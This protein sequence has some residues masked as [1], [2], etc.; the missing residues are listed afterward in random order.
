[1]PVTQHLVWNLTDADWELN[2]ADAFLG[3]STDV[4]G[5]CSWNAT[6]VDGF[7]IWQQGIPSNLTSR[8]V[9]TMSAASSSLQEGT[10]LLCEYLLQIFLK[11]VRFP[12]VWSLIV[13]YLRWSRPEIVLFFGH[14]S[15]IVPEIVPYSRWLY[16]CLIMED[17]NFP[18]VWSLIV[19]YPRWSEPEIVHMYD[20]CLDD[21]VS[22]IQTL[23]DVYPWFH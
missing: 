3:N 19:P 2:I 17:T 9:F 7:G 18:V 14:W 22:K 12:V 6:D 10:P 4:D 23:S 8:T 21:S 1:M 5:L 11:K 13:L 15:L 16:L 20:P